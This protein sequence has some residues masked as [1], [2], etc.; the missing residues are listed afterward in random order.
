M[1]ED[2]PVTADNLNDAIDTVFQHRYT[3]RHYDAS[4]N[5]NDRDWATIIHAGWRSPSSMGFEPWE[6]VL[7]NDKDIRNDLTSIV[8]GAQ[9]R[10][11]EASHFLLIATRVAADMHP[12]T[13]YMN[14]ILRNQGHDEA[15][16]EARNKKVEKFVG[17]D[18][19]THWEDDLVEGW[20]QRQAYIALGNMMS[21]ASM[22]GIDSTPIEGFNYDQVNN[23]MWE[24]GILDPKHFQVGCFAAFG[25]SRQDGKTKLRRDISEVYREV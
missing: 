11:E 23:F 19:G 9:G 25:Y 15:G 13:A 6:F 24:R 4:R 7:I 12:G 22:L 8:W 10:C 3:C 14:Q 17:T 20:V 21:V 18:K 2:A 1:G 16:I 5:I